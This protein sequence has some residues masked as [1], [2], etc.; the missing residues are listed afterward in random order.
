MFVKTKTR[1]LRY[2]IVKKI[3]PSL[4]ENGMHYPMRPFTAQLTKQNR[5]LIGAEV[6]VYEGKN[7]QNILNNTSTITLYLIDPYEEYEDYPDFKIWKR[8]PLIEAEAEAH[9]RLASYDKQVVWVRQKFGSLLNYSFPP[10]DFVYI[11]GNHKYEYVL[12]DIQL[13]NQIVKVGGLIGGHNYFT[14]KLFGGVKKAVDYFVKTNNIKLYTRNPDW[15]F[16]K[17]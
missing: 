3:A 9:Q 13:A 15:W 7:A 10:L 12:E 2:Y 17:C 5:T 4:Y 1:R 14:T 6:G 16:L 11:D 8:R